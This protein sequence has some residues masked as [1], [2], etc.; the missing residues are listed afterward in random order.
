MRNLWVPVYPHGYRYGDD[1]L[2]VNEYEVR[3]IYYQFL[4]SLLVAA[5]STMKVETG[6]RRNKKW[7][8][9]TQTTCFP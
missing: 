4:L 8:V 1:L 9:S 7:L 3:Y 5:I 6:N 2:P